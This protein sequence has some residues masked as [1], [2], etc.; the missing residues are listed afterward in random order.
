MESPVIQLVRQRSEGDCGIAV[1]AMYLRL[2]Y[3]D[4]LIAAGQIDQNIHHKGMWNWQIKETARVLGVP[5]KQKRKWD[6]ETAEGILILSSTTH[7]DH[8]VVLKDGLLFDTELC[9]W[10]PDVLFALKNYKATM[11]LQRRDEE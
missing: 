5:L 1:L 3:E 2:S 7:Y 6:L 8:V 9:V 11:L 10:E 4:V